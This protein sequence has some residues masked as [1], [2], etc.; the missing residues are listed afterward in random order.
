[1]QKRVTSGAK[2]LKLQNLAVH[3]DPTPTSKPWCFHVR[4]ITNQNIFLV[5]AN[6]IT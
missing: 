2:S 1:M 3:N 4:V 5:A 6:S